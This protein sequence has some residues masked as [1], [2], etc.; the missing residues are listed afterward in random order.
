MTQPS[1]KPAQSINSSGGDVDMLLLIPGPASEKVW[2]Q[3]CV[4]RN[5]KEQK[6]PVCSEPAALGPAACPCFGGA[7]LAR[8]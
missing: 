2:V 3:V 4:K 7:G 6:E 5:R 8:S 1:V